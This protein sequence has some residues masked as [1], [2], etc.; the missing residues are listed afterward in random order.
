[1]KKIALLAL[2][3]ANC[4]VVASGENL[5][6]EPFVW[7]NEVLA[8]VYDA[9]GDA[10]VA[11][12]PRKGHVYDVRAQTFHVELIAPDGK[13]PVHFRRNFRAENG[14]GEYAFE[15]AFN[16]K[17]GRWTVVVRHV[18]TG[19]ERIQVLEVR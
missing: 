19:T 11:H 5:A 2:I 15:T 16:E 4:A 6:D 3:G 17:P 14:R 7:S 8:A 10:V 18:N 13:S 12:L 1:M 9:K